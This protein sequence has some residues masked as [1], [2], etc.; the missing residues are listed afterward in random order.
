LELAISTFEKAVADAVSLLSRT[1][2]HKT[3]PF[4]LVPARH[5]LHVTVVEV[6]GPEHTMRD[7]TVIV[8]CES[9]SPT[10]TTLVTLSLSE[11][12]GYWLAW[13][14]FSIQYGPDYPVA[15]LAGKSISTKDI[16]PAFALRPD[17]EKPAAY[18]IRT[19]AL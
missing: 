13:G 19:R 12:H 8:S 16:Y 18:R 2:F 5:L 9:W 14:P 15:S 10:G 6:V 17:Y 1:R 11:N 4:Y 7:A 3:A